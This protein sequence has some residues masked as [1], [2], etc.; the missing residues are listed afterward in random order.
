VLIAFANLSETVGIVGR[1]HALQSRISI[2]VC[3]LL[4]L[5]L[6]VTG[7][8]PAAGQIQVAAAAPTPEATLPDDAPQMTGLSLNLCVDDS[9]TYPCPNPIL[10]DNRYIPSI[11]L[12]YGQILDGVVAYSPPSLTF[13][14]ITIYKDPGTGPVPIC[15]L[16][17]GIDNSCPSN[18]TIFDVGDYTLTAELTFPQDPSYPSSSA[19]PVTVS[20]SKDTSEVAVSSS[21]PVATLGSAV[22]ITATATGGYGAIPTGQVVF[23]VDGMPLTPVALDTTGTASFTTSTLALGTHN[24]S[25]SYAG[26]LDFYPAADS[27]VFKQQI[28]PPPTVSAVTS[29]LNPSAIGDNVT[30]TASIAPAAGATG[31]LSGTVVFRDGNIAFATQPIVQRGSQYVAQATI[32]T[33]GF[34]SHSIT[35]A[36]SGDGSNSASVSPPYVQQVN[37]PL[38]QAPPGYRITVT[39]SPVAM[40]VGQTVDLTVTVT[41]VS[42]FLQTVTLSCAGLPTESACTFGETVIPAGGGSTT[43][44]L[45]TMAPHD[46]GSSIPYF[47]GQAGLHH[48]SSTVRYA[49][50]LLAGLLV[51][52]L[53]RRR[54]RMRRMRPLLALAFACGLLAL[55]GCGGNCTDFGTP[56]GGYTLKV[57]GTSSANGTATGAPSAT[58]SN[59][60]NVSTSVAISVKL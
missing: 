12:T 3:R 26:A 14:T 32:S 18:A 2:C 28:V 36:Y 60:V 56:P 48:P 29:S 22:T 52:V 54:R 34:G 49:A 30:F 58:A 24:I 8:I 9:T 47:T 10:S 13:G 41:P 45:S 40:G 39:P 6:A 23:T 51:L 20:V 38:T 42:G 31:G 57:N 5:L 7:V 33:L 43:L 44:S 27:P 19:L 59:A 1:F 53:P 4:L 50:P 25:A 37:Y 11:T 15:V 46:C 21:Q 17:I 16:K 35:A 55:N